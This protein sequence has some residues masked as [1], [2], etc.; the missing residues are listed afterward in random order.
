MNTKVQDI[1]AAMSADELTSF[2]A[3]AAQHHDQSTPEFLAATKTLI[4]LQDRLGQDHPEVVSE[5][6]RVW[7]MGPQAMRDFWAD[8]HAKRE[9]RA[10]EIELHRKQSTPEY[11]AAVVEAMRLVEL[12]G[13]DHPD[14]T[15]AICTAMHL[16]PETMKKWMSEKVDELDLLPAASGYSDNDEPVYRLGDIAQKLGISDA[17]AIAAAERVPGGLVHQS[18]FHSIQ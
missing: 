16:A 9:Q 11:R 4:A 10:A 3:A 6:A 5:A 12:H 2:K 8:F 15:A 17:Q 13:H 7:Q 14:T 1:Y 18:Q